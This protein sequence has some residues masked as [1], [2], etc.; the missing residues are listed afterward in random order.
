MPVN[1]K[2]AELTVRLAPNALTTL[3]AVMEQIGVEK[4]TASVA[5]MNNVARLIN[6]ASAWL[7]TI[8]GRKLGRAEYTQ[9]Y[10]AS[11]SQELVLQQ[12]PIR[13]VEYVRD[14]L[15][16]AD[17]IAESYDIT[18]SGDVGI[19]FRDT[20]WLFLGYVGGLANDFT[21]ARHYL[22]VKYTA[23]YILPKDATED[24]PAD[25]PAD[26]EGVIWGIVEQEF[27]I[28][29]NG[30]QGLSAFSISDVS[31]TFDKEPRQSWLETI[32]RYM[33]W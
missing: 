5:V 13:A 17:I 10:A 11:G 15:N 32:N 25:L 9:R 23:G 33:R 7:E 22:E 14:T 26:L 6:A 28:K 30:A 29:R 24:E 20:G 18:M 12:W 27:S 3:E 8:I 16:G 19:I 1:K 21:A 2:K 31:W 4:E